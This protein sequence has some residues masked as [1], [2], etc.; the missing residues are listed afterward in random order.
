MYR[1]C[2]DVIY[3]LLYIRGSFPKRG[4]IDQKACSRPHKYISI[5]GLLWKIMDVGHLIMCMY[6][7]HTNFEGWG[8]IPLLALCRKNPAYNNTFK[9][10]GSGKSHILGYFSLSKYLSTASRQ[11]CFSE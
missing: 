6:M 8:E 1:C 2:I 7:R 5:V 11:Y 9:C 4:K 10:L 3:R